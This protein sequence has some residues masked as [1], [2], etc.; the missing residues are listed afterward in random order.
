MRNNNSVINVY[1]KNNI[2]SEL[3]TQLLYGET[4]RK[5]KIT[6]KWIKIKND[7]DNYKGYIKNKKFPD[8]QKNTHK[9][10]SISA[11]LYSKPNGKQEIKKKLSFGSRIK[12][13][14]KKGNYYKFDNFWIDKKNLKNINYK[15]N[16]FF[17]NI[18]KFINTKY[19]W[20]GKH[21]GGID[22]SA[23]VQLFLNFN[24]KFCPRDS[25]DQFKYFRKK[26]ELKNVKKNDLIFWK[27]HVAIVTSKKNLI[28]AYGP[29]KKTVAMPINKAINRIYKTAGLKVT[30]IR[31]IP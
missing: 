20:G 3:V 12:I 11:I 24:N 8:N 2:K 21:F 7:I 19:K 16:D 30:G 14:K 31:R 6:K 15:S 26:V 25:G 22:C 13:L 23:L 1:K 17:K 9:V 18:K 28:H 10:S 29:Y 5:I 27:G 4:F